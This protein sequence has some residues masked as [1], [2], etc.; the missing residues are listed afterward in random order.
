MF[1]A[2]SH[3]LAPVGVLV[4]GLAYLVCVWVMD[5]RTDFLTQ[6]W[7]IPVYARPTAYGAWVAISAAVLL[8]WGLRRYGE[9]WRAKFA[10]GLIL[11]SLTYIGFDLLY[12]AAALP[13]GEFWG[14]FTQAAMARW[15]LAPIF[16]EYALTL[17]IACAALWITTRPA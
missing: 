12:T 11:I 15:L 6:I 17:V 13:P 5:G 16:A 1:V 2:A 14:Y 7:T 9:A 10:V 8:A 3:R 4:F